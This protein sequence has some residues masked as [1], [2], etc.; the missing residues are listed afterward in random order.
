MTPSVFA[1]AGLCALC[2]CASSRSVIYYHYH[3]VFLS[4]LAEVEDCELGIAGIDLAWSTT[5][6]SAVALL[7]QSEAAILVHVPELDRPKLAALA[8]AAPA[9]LSKKG[10]KAK[11]LA[12]VPTAAAPTQSSALTAGLEL[13]N[14]AAASSNP[15][16]AVASS[17]VGA[18]DALLA[19][20]RFRRAFLL[21][22]MLFSHEYSTPA[23]AP[24]RWGGCTFDLDRAHAAL[25]AAQRLLDVVRRTSLF[26]AS[27]SAPGEVHGVLPSFVTTLISGGLPRFVPLPTFAG[28][29]DAWRKL[30]S[31]A[32]AVCEIPACASH[33]PLAENL[34][35]PQSSSPP[36]VA[37]VA[38]PNTVLAAPGDV[39][40]GPNA[41]PTFTALSALASAS[42]ALA[43]RTT[44]EDRVPFS[45]R[46]DEPAL[47]PDFAGPTA[48]FVMQSGS[49]Q[50]LPTR[51]V[52][53]GPKRAHVSLDAL[54]DAL[55][56]FSA[57]DACVLVRCW[58]HR[59]LCGVRDRPSTEKSVASSA[60]KAADATV[61]TPHHA[62]VSGAAHPVAAEAIAASVPES[63]APAPGACALPDTAEA[64]VGYSDF[65]VAAAK[66]LT[67]LGS[68]T[69][70]ELVLGR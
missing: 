9:D 11:A 24:L 50:A 14:P 10:K 60:D 7:R 28:A 5:N 59:V 49:L 48:F 53:L 26:D 2:C 65:P 45:G 27:D 6:E 8:A 57:R 69:L 33:N 55:E 25:A 40:R 3:L 12:K 43:D 38:L 39:M 64:D 63:P 54:L 58:L 44:I 41:A 4:D 1:S 67:V 23:P 19:R 21:S 61:A 68:H 29:F 13:D 34:P 46:I 62:T 15:A 30:V 17:D 35:V 32:L 36:P 52:R 56:V 20:V 66:S 22:C 37:G 42:R 16:T 70:F 31:D 47:W 51:E 18:W